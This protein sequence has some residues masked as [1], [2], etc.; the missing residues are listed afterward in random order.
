MAL[1]QIWAIAAAGVA[2]EWVGE[3]VVGVRHR[4]VAARLLRLVSLA[5]LLL[6]RL[7]GLEEP[8]EH[9]TSSPRDALACS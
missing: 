1:G 5:I 8:V 6:V 9:R 4:T 3:R 7:V 2:A